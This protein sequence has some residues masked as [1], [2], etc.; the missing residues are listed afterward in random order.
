MITIVGKKEAVQAAKEKIAARVAQLENTTEDTVEVDPVYYKD[1][2]ANRGR[3]LREL[4]DDFGGVRIDLPRAGDDGKY[5]SNAIRLKGSK[6]D[7]PRAIARINEY[8]EEVKNRVTVEL[9][10]PGSAIPAVLGSGGSNV[11]RISGEYNVN[12]K[13][14]DRKRSERSEADAEEKSETVFVSGARANCEQAI[15]ELQALVPQT[16]TIEIDNKYHVAIIGE[17]GSRITQLQTET[18]VRINLRKNSNEVAIRGTKA[19]IEAAKAKLAALIA[20]L[21]LK[22]YTETLEVD[23]KY[24][25]ALKGERGS[26]IIEFSNKFKVNISFPR[27]AKR[28]TA[29]AAAAADGEDEAA[30]SPAAAAEA[31]EKLEEDEPEAEAT[32]EAE[33]EAEGEGEADGEEAPE[34]VAL[35]VQVKVKGYEKDVKAAVVALQEKIKEL[36]S[37]VRVELSIDPRVHFRLVGKA[38][39]NLKALQDKYKV[40]IMFPRNKDSWKIEIFGT[41][42]GCDEART[43][44]EFDAEDLLQDIAEKEHL[45][46]YI[47]NPTRSQDS[48]RA[49]PAAPFQV[50]GA[51]WQAGATDFPSLGGSSKSSSAPTWV[52]K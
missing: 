3:F 37:L 41:E 36:E 34:E 44:L 33:G 27:P 9:Q 18:N 21:K 49:A 48:E 8:V 24:I 47:R 46:K 14:P 22:E 13:F 23:P 38:G 28:A 1:L 51:P 5:A 29:A 35:P 10:I 26:S 25:A 4:S 32:A 30:A 15:A 2:T 39:A 19:D 11:I 20:D 31:T 7:V 16:E 43:K 42:S 50:R 40:R 52:R 17:K 12:I 6:A 45:Q